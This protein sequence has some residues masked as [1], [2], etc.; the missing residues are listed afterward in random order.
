MT[1]QEKIKLLQGISRG[2]KPIE[3]NPVLIFEDVDGSPDLFIENRKKIM[4]KSEME[5]YIK[6]KRNPFIINWAV[7]NR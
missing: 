5:N 1:R 3:D 7:I 2:K 4:K 6:S